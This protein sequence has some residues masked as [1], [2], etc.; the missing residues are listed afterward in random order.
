[1]KMMR[2]SG[3]KAY[4][5]WLLVNP[6]HPAVRHNI[7][8]PVLDAIQDKVYREIHTRIDTTNI[9]I[10]NAVSDYRIVPYTL[11]WWEAE[12]AKE[13]EVFREIVLEH[14]PRILISFGAFPFEFLRRVFGIK[15]EKGPKY[16]STANL[17]IEFNNSIENFDINET[18][19]IPLLRRILASDNFMEAHN[20]FGQKDGED[21]YY[22]VGKRI[23]EKIIENKDRLNIWIK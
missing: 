6:K 3:D 4:P 1:M 21:Y 7:W 14:K 9:F 17:E 11:N 23:A 13:I 19:R 22:N 8:S 15:P 5:I 20:C 18:N 12:I 16:W 2:E 10:R